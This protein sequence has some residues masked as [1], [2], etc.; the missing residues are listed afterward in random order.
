LNHFAGVKQHLPELEI[1]QLA[2]RAESIAFSRRKTGE[3]PVVRQIREDGHA[4]QNAE[5]RW[6]HQSEYPL[7]ETA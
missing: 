1:D 3:N 5:A 4:S 2:R 7:L 6:R